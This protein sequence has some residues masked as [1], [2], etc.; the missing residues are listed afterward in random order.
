MPSSFHVSDLGWKLFFYV[1]NLFVEKIKFISSFQNYYCSKNGKMQNV[2]LTRISVLNTKR[3][4][5]T[6]TVRILVY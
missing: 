1:E 5:K 4:L 3:K 2:G 6:E